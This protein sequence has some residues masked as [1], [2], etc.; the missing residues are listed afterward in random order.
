[1]KLVVV[2]E[3]DNLAE[4]L[5]CSFAWNVSCT[6]MHH[7]QDDMHGLRIPAFSF[8]VLVAI[9]GRRAFLLGSGQG[10]LEDVGGLDQVL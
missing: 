2:N 3:D 8:E 9:F 4:H 1:M 7:A 10:H 6:V 5:K